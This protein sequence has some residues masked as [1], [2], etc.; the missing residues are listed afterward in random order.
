LAAFK[1][2][3]SADIEWHLIQKEIKASDAEFLLGNP[4][5]ITYQSL[6]HDFSDTAA[7]I[8]E[9]DL[10]ISVDTAVAH[11]SGALGK[12]VWILLPYMADYRWLLDRADSPWYPSATLFRQ[13]HEDD[14]ISVVAAV[15][16]SLAIQLQV[17]IGECR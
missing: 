2:L 12:P 15:K 13:V 14:W 9:L 8:A 17:L 5:I 4:Q 11:L 6:L 7:L 1:S 10:V 3:L 16:Q